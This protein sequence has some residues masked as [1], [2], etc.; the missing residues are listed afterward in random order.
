MSTPDRSASTI[1]CGR[2]NQMP[3]SVDSIQK[4]T[5]NQALAGLRANPDHIAEILASTAPFDLAAWRSGS[6]PP[7]PDELE[8]LE[9]QRRERRQQ[10]RISLERQDE[11]E[12]RDGRA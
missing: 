12:R 1:E 3:N 6:V 10:R 7:N 8:D 5:I 2:R 9:A 4:S 11:E